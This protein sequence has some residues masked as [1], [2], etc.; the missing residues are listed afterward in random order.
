MPDL[1]PKVDAVDQDDAPEVLSRHVAEVVKKAL[2]AAKPEERVALANRLMSHLDHD[3]QITP[4]P[5]QL[6]S[7]HR[8]DALKRRQL[9]RPTTRLS[10]SALLTNGKDDPNLAAEL[11]TEIESANTV[12]LLCAFVRWTGLRL[13]EPALEQLNERG[14]KFRVITTTYMGATE[15]RAI[16]ELVRRYGAEVKISYETQATRLHAKAWLFRRRT[17]FDTAYVGSSNLS[18]AALLDGLEWNVRL[19]SIA[20]PELLKKFEVTFDS[21]WEQKAFQT[22]D[23]DR[24]GDRLDA[25]LERNGGRRTAA[26]DTVTGL[27]VVPFLHQ[28]EMLEDLEAERSKGFNRNLLVAATG[29]GKTVIAALDYKRLCEAAGRPLSLLF[30]AHRQ[31]I[32]KQSL[33][34]YRNVLQD[35]AFGELYVGDHKPQDWKHLFASVQSLASLGVSN[36]EVEQFDVVVIDEFHHALAPTYRQLLDYLQ[37]QQLLGLTATPERGDGGNVAK[38]FFEGRT[39]SALRL[40]DALD[41]DLL[42][43]FH[44]FGV[45]DDVDL[46]R[47]EWK[48]GNYDTAQLDR[49]YT[50]N[51]ARA[52]KVIRE[53]RDKVVGTE[54]MRALGFCVSVQHAHYMARVFNDAGIT[55]VAVDGGTDEA[56]RADALARLRNR[57]VNCI[58]AVDIFNEGLDIP[59]VDTI[60]MLRPTQS[61]TIFLQQLGRG[62]RRADDKAV[63]TVLDFIGQQR[64]EF[65]FDLRYRALTG[66]GRKQLEKAVE[67][68]FPYLPS[69]S[70]IVL[71][72]V[73]QKVVLD[74]IKAQLRF[75]RNQLINDVASY[76][77]T[78]LASYLRE[79]GNDVKTIYRSTRDS[80]TD[81]L[82]QAQ[83]I[84]GFSPLESV[85]KGIHHDRS[86][87][88][89]KKL[90]GRMAALIHVDDP[91]RAEAYSMLV[92]A[93]APRYAELG[94]REQSFARMLFY[95]L[96][97]DGGGFKTYDDGLDHLRAY[98]F[99]CSEIKQIVSLGVAASK[100]AAKGLGAGLQHIPLLTHATYRREEVLA[101]LQFGSLELGKNVQHRE[102]VAW[103]PATA[104]DAFFVT[105]NKD[106]RKHS[107][108]TMYKDYAISPELFH[109]ESQNATSS[110]SPTG[111]RYLD[112]RAH[113]SHIVLFTRDTA[114]DESGLTVPYTCLGQ[115]DYLQHSGEKPIGITWKLHRPMPV[116]VYTKAAA[117]AR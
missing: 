10:D 100:H 112:R 31:E 16:D 14:V 3:D 45:S 35:G 98:G 34:T 68:E 79:S 96:W 53:L 62:L 20:T 59:E 65:R 55:S 39:A 52:A 101:A 5:Q 74:N 111:K 63:L 90:L 113:G 46:S 40:W 73:A 25:A 19:S 87:A 77:E 95:T 109:W 76:G 28:E 83:L 27:E 57:E 102:G 49:L 4:G 44:Y 108:T 61:A 72:R 41:A 6:L 48:R 18:Q 43:P 106:D 86:S 51:D 99:V 11:R 66:Y 67:E 103:C 97:D 105:L 71:D 117:V 29:T 89:E 84:D 91:G 82:R 104:T 88:E 15:R 22:Y 9:R 92:S 75:N 78:V 32:L 93:D 13:L 7:L 21:Y 42:V 47:L 116:D 2:T 24:D 107:A 70:Q 37:P 56:A 38:E 64:R 110:T 1:S 30:V 94:T 50:G 80:W 54:H 12:D 58:F 81:Y 60:L 26:P 85:L 69:G 23:P 36:F 8:P 114:E 17:G 33:R 115:M